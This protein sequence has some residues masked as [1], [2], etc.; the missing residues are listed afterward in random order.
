VSDVLAAAEVGTDGAAVFRFAPGAE[1]LHA[2]AD[3][4]MLRQVVANLVDNAVKYSPDGGEIHV[5]VTNSH[6]R[7]EIAVSDTGIGVP[8]DAQA[9]IFEKFFRADPNLSRGVG[10]TGLGLYIARQLTERMNGRLT[11]RSTAGR[12]STFAVELPV[13]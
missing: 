13:G 7:I 12:G 3:H 11:L 10:G 4:G 9:R 6:R 8:A 1:P 5:S 2:L